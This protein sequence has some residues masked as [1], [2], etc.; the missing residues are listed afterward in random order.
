MFDLC[1]YVWFNIRSNTEFKRFR[2]KVD[3]D[4]RY[5]GINKFPQKL[6]LE[7]RPSSDSY[8]KNLPKS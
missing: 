4:K 7:K 6:S 8:H 2:T 1:E 3:K 5:F